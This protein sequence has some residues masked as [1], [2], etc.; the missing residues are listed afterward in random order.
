MP[1]P[2]AQ[3]SYIEIVQLVAQSVGHPKPTD[4]AGSQDEAV[5]RMGWYA[6][7]ACTELATMA[8]WNE[9]IKPYTI[10]IFN[11][12]VGQP[13]KSFE[14]P[15]DFYGFV[16]NTQWNRS[17][18]LPAIGPVTPQ[19]WQ[20]LVVRQA[21]ITTRFMWRLR[22]GL[23]W[24][25]TP[26]ESPQPFVFEYTGKNW[27]IDGVTGVEKD[28]MT[29]NSDY[30]VYPW[31]VVVLLTRVKWLK[32]EGYDSTQAERDFSRTLEA[33]EGSNFGNA[34]L[35]LVP[36]GGYPYLNANRNAPDTGYGR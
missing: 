25:K 24:I 35:N 19:D 31:D 10:S 23:L 20:W 29:N 27:C 26:P 14:L 33:R 34:T 1:A 7:Q 2:A 6:N 32:N 30:H 36:G 15:A 9:L 4:V 22:N 5:L 13:E 28:L 16:D 21:L 3:T 12:Y 8:N 17:T 18:Q 11:D